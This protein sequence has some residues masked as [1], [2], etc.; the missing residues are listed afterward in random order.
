M[1]DETTLEAADLRV[2]TATVV[3]RQP[4]AYR[5]V[6]LD[7][8]QA[9]RLV[10]GR[11]GD[12]ALALLTSATAFSVAAL[13]P[14]ATLSGPGGPMA[15]EAWFEARAFGPDGELRWRSPAGG[16]TWAVL[17]CDSEAP[18][19]DGFERLELPGCGLAL[20]RRQLLWGRVTPVSPA[21]GWV[22]LYEWRVGPI[23]IPCP[24]PA[25]TPGAEDGTDRLQLVGHELLAVG[26]DGNA[27]VVDEQ[28]R[29]ITV[30]ERV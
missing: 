30:A 28:L 4:L 18:P 24:E 12:P 27:Y 23:D 9:L 14:Q 22:T 17:L 3:E 21:P 26:E 20:E 10:R 6:G 1:R 16:P 11:L 8:L 25:P 7:L 15:T 29:R 5:S 13:D 2:K 19:P